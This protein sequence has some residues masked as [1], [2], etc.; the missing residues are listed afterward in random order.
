MGIRI[1]GKGNI[2]AEIVADSVSKAGKRI[3]T[4]VLEYPRFIHGEVMT[5]RMFSR[6]AASSR[7]IPIKKMIELVKKQCAMPIHWGANQ[8]GMQAEKQLTGIKLK[9]SKLSWHLA[10]FCATSV[11]WLLTKCGAHK[12][13]VNRILEPFQM[14]RT[15]VT[16]TEWN[17]FFWLR[18]HKDAQPE[19]K[20]LAA[21][22]LQ[23][24]EMSVPETLGGNEWHTPFVKH[25]RHPETGELLYHA[26][27][28]DV[29]SWE[30]ALKISAS[31]C[32]QVS[33]R[34][35]DE[36]VEKADDIYRRLIESEPVHA[37][38]VE[39]Q[40]TPMEVFYMA[41][42]PGG[43]LARGVTTRDRDKNVWSG[44]FNGWIQARQLIENNVRKG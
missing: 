7:A 23:A 9:L 15:I 10:A 40:A 20:E 16:A 35:L 19:I 1:T 4:F 43:N 44:N 28:E 11:A 6:N 3:T 17:N 13:I 18:H 25:S 31:C 32:A 39:H 2:S 21:V 5:H 34:K 24:R 42:W 30:Q 12:Q 8:S 41:E 27:D 37:S 36:S 22:M 38:P 26:K 14:M 29:I 33:Y